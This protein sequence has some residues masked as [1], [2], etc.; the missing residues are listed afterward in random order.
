M[1]GPSAGGFDLLMVMAEPP[2]LLILKLAL[3]AS[4]TA[5]LPKSRV[6]GSMVSFPGGA[7]LPDS[8]TSTAPPVESM[9]RWSTKE[10]IAV[11]AKVTPTVTVSPAA[12]VAPTIGSP[13]AE[14]GAC[15]KVR[16][17]MVSGA[18]PTLAKSRFA[19][20]VVPIAVP[21]KL[22]AFDE[23]VSTAAAD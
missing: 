11:G 16:L 15:G 9:I 21:P 7:A 13:P 12:M 1:N 14:K 8:C 2:L 10:P 6:S 5:T 20:S 3:L 19:L 18:A 17:R 4:P 22:I 23:A